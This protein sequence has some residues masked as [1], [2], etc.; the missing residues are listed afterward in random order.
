[1]VWR[2]QVNLRTRIGLAVILSLGLFASA[3]A[4]YKTPMQYNFFKE[5]D[6]SGHGSW[7]YIWQQVE[8]HI[9]IL[10]ACL[11]T[12]KPLFASFF[13]QIR[14]FT[15]GRTTGSNGVS[16][17]FRSNG[18]VKQNDAGNSFAMKNMSEGSQS[19]L[20]SPYDEDVI[21]GKESYSVTT[22]G[23]RRDRRHSRAGDSDES[24]LSHDH[25]RS[26]G[27]PRGMAIVRTTEVSVTR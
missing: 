3:V 13:G 17:P 7:Y 8:M 18:Y 23:G 16:T 25:R 15:K 1:M 2:L 11:P 14:T 9:G 27:M 19:Q 24:I 12:L 5:A 10:A 20:R 6:F 21:L 26:N 22:N 4:I